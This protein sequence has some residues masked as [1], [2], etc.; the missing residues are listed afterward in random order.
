VTEL[1]PQLS[2]LGPCLLPLQSQDGGLT[3]EV[4]KLPQSPGFPPRELK[5]P[6]EWDFP[7]IYP[8]DANTLAQYD[9]EQMD[10]K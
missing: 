2:K 9:H 4:A 3:W 5:Y 8:A 1:P 7:R 10:K 6:P